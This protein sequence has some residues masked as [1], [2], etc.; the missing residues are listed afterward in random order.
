[1]SKIDWQNQKIKK[2]K[3]IELVV[4]EIK[5]ATL[6]QDFE[7]KRNDLIEQTEMKESIFRE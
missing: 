4:L 1:M 5:L 2:P 7:E 3:N 6:K